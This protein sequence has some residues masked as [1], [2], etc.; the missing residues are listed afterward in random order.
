MTRTGLRFGAISAKKKKKKSS[1]YIYKC[2]K[3]KEKIEG[4]SI[5]KKRLKRLLTKFKMRTLC[6]I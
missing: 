4:Q 2:M 5:A 6:I 3:Q 1:V